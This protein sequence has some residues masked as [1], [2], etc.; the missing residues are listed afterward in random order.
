MRA[1]AC[2]VVVS[3]G[4]ALLATLASRTGEAG[5]AFTLIVSKANPVASLSA[6]DVK[7]LVSGGTKVW[8]SGAVVQLGIIPGDAPETAYLASVLDTTPRELM[9]LIQQQVFKGEL[10]RPIVLHGGGDC[11]ALAASNPGA[12]CVAA[13]GAAIPDGARALPLR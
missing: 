6:S 3:V 13:T 10:R 9:S 11:G 7:R 4:A 1:R 5:G 12:F 8:D 2:V